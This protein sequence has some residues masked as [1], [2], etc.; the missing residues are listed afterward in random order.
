MDSPANLTANDMLRASRTA[1]VPSA[2]TPKHILLLSS[3]RMAFYLAAAEEF[4]ELRLRVSEANVSEVNIVSPAELELGLSGIG[5]SVADLF[6]IHQEGMSAAILAVDYVDKYRIRVNGRGRL[7]NGR[8]HLF[9]QES[10]G[11]CNLYL[12]QP[13][14]DAATRA[15]FARAPSDLP[16]RA[17]LTTAQRER[18]HGA[19]RFVLASTS[20]RGTDVSHRGGEAGFVRAAETEL[21]FPDY[22]GNKMFATFGNLLEDGRCALLFPAHGEGKS[23]EIVGRARIEYHSPNGSELD[24]GRSVRTHIERIIEE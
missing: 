13:A 11:N 19:R 3:G 20:P 7:R 22:P 14:D 1:R 4:G 9:V 2:M 23:L 17:R 18:I 10:F 6:S 8:F 21:V 15:A 5:A 16:E 12:S 24:T